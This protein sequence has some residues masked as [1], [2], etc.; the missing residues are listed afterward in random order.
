MNL[1]RI[2]APTIAALVGLTAEAAAQMPCADLARLRS[3][4]AETSKLATR[5]PGAELCWSYSQFA[6]AVTAVVEYATNHQNSC[7]IS[8]QWLYDMLRERDAAVKG[9]DNVCAGHPLN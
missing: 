3:E 8:P 9:R 7:M 6:R 4:L 5:A 2:S 1:L